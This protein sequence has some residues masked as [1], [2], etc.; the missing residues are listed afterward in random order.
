MAGFR[1]VGN[2]KVYVS[3]CGLIDVSKEIEKLNKDIEKV[4]KNLKEH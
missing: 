3:L 4:K 2:T 1:I